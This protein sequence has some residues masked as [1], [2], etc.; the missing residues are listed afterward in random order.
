MSLELDFVAEPER[1]VK[2]AACIEAPGVLEQQSAGFGCKR[3]PL[4]VV[5]SRLLNALFSQ[6]GDIKSLFLKMH[7]VTLE[8]GLCLFLLSAFAARCGPCTFLQAGVAALGFASRSADQDKAWN[9]VFGL[10][11][12][13]CMEEAEAPVLRE[14]MC[15]ECEC[16]LSRKPLKLFARPH[17]QGH[18][19][20]GPMRL[21]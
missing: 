6:G 14:T 4:L 1:H 16:R 20:L 10:F 8:A 5:R 3:Q 2:S 11:F 17:V 13:R 9:T 15:L 18:D 12:S 7:G 19:P 21:V